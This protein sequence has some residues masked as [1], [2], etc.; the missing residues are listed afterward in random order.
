MVVAQIQ[1]LEPWEVDGDWSSEGVVLE[2]Q[3]SE[4]C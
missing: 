3:A 2:V 1:I 4:M